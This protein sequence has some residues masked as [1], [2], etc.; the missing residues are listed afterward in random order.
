M[1]E[2]GDAIDAYSHYLNMRALDD[3][4]EESKR[5]E[6]LGKAKREIDIIW[7]GLKTRDGRAAETP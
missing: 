6:D 3:P 7:L 4:D 5:Q 2:L 1:T